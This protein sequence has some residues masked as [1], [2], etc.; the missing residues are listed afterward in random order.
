MKEQLEYPTMTTE[1]IC[2]MPV[3][4]IAERGAHLWLWTTNQH[5]EDG[6][7][8]MR[9]WG[10]RYMAPITWVKPSGIGMIFVHRTQT[11]L[12]GYKDFNAFNKKRCLPTVI[13]AGLPKRHSQKP[14]EAY[15]M[16][17]A[18]SDPARLEL[19]ARPVSPMF[20]KRDG[21]D[22]WGNEMPNDVDLIV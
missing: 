5:L 8:V 11:I 19:F 14:E 17:E 2:N 7:K 10:F 3:G 15:Q 16:I 12:F 13:M 9:A 18:M 21:W 1:A 20:Q 22:T 4:D 6:F